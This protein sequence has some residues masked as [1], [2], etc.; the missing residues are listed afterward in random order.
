M[1]IRVIPLFLS[2]V[3]ASPV[4]AAN[5][6]FRDA[7][8]RLDGEWLGE[9]YALRV[10]S[11]RAQANLDLNRPFHWERFLVKEVSGDTV[12]FTVGAELFEATL[13]AD[14]LKLT[15][16]SFRGERLLRRHDKV[17]EPAIDLNALGLRR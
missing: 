6:S 11:Y 14:R 4:G 15:S 12:T 2:L 7:A 9:N 5:S 10:D 16:T 8:E 13:D 3:L 17:P 1:R